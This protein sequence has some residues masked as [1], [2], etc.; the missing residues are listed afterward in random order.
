M[1]AFDF[2]YKL[3]ETFLILRRIQRDIFIQV[4]TSSCELPMI[5][6]GFEWHLS[7]LDR[8]S[9]K[10]QILTLIQNRP[11]GAELFHADGRTDVQAD[12]TKLIVAFS[13]FASA[14]DTDAVR[15]A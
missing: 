15:T 3:D 4:K 7:F 11:V 8:F 10:A 9:K 14:P 2:L 13:N 5:Y 1:H 12:T 6:V